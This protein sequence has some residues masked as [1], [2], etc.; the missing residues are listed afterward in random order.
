MRRECVFVIALA[1]CGTH[2]L[3]AAGD[4]G[5]DAGLAPDASTTDANMSP[6]ALTIPTDHPRLWFAT[7]ELRARGLANFQAAYGSDGASFD[8]KDDPMSNALGYLMTKNPAYAQVAIT[9]ALSV[10]DATI[11]DPSP[12][13]GPSDT[14]RWYGEAVALIYDWCHDA[15]TDD[16]R[17]TLMARWN[18][19]VA[20]ENGRIWGG[21]GM[22][23]DNY[24]WGHLRTSFDWGVATTGESPLAAGFISAVVD[25]QLAQAF[26]PFAGGQGAGGIPQEGTEYGH[27]NLGYPVVPF[28]TAQALGLPLYDDGNFFPGSVMFLIYSATPAPTTIGASAPSLQVFPF[29]DDQNWHNG[30]S[31]SGYWG[32]FLQA[33]ATEWSG[34]AVGKLARHLLTT[35][36]ASRDDYV[37]IL[38]QRTSGDD[39]PFDALPLDYYAPGPGY[40]FA[41]TA[42]GANATSLFFQ[43]DQP[44][45][46][47]HHHQDYGTFQMWRN[48]RWLSRETASYADQVAGFDQSGPES[49]AL[50]SAHNGILFEGIG[51]NSY[52][53][54]TD[55]YCDGPPVVTRVASRDAYTFASVDL[56]KSYRSHGSSYLIANTNRLRDDN[57]HVA[58]VVRD[59]VFVRG[60]ETLVVLDRLQSSAF[61][62]QDAEAADGPIS[63]HVDD[64][65]AVRK[66][67]LAHFEEQ[68]VIAGNVTTAD[69]GG[70]VL[71]V[72]SAYPAN[73][74]IS[75]VDETL[76]ASAIG[77]Y[78]LEVTT[79]GSAQSYMIHVLQGRDTNAPDVVATVTESA[80]ELVLDLAMGT[81][82]AIIHFTKGMSSTGGSFNGDPFLDHVQAVA[83]TPEGPTWGN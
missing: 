60:M 69:Y 38:D 34:H 50:T 30:S 6:G 53:A 40:L 65:T 81:Q 7:P 77:Q 79:S 78:R 2:Q 73:P 76:G 43:L 21:P 55:N 39:Q 63:P 74:T 37:A 49:A 56:S 10:V 27:Y 47:G 32:D 4:D 25:T 72:I 45:A 3:P 9:Y 29:N 16:Q 75:V 14:F 52:Y 17:A 59:F 67:F 83:L 13:A 58:N 24:F 22:E 35:T 41:R 26:V 5:V 31:M 46:I 51:D 80:T 33:A 48:G 66:T 61:D 57:P 71:R 64:P 44:W 18:M 70:Q 8:P 12:G 68:P 11:D 15:F 20:N 19:Y 42:W 1:G 82:K 23:M 62:R 28:L 54:R 36:S